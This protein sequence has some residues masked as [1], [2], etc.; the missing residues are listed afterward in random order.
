MNEPLK[1]E[2]TERTSEEIGMERKL[3]YE[4]TLKASGLNVDN[5][6]FP[7][8]AALG[9]VAMAYMT[10]FASTVGSHHASKMC[11]EE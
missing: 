1:T 3:A 9:T 4:N 11:G 2:K 7:L 5:F 8:L 10:G 6:L